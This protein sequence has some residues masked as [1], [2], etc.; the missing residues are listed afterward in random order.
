M[1]RHADEARMPRHVTSYVACLA[2]CALVLHG[3]VWLR[4]VWLLCAALHAATL[5]ATALHTAGTAHHLS[6]KLRDL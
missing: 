1:A 5:H 3:V 4:S 6:G 2:A